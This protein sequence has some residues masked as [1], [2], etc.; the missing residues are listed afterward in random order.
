MG[1][2][3]KIQWTDRG[4]TTTSDGYVLILVGKEH[5]LAD[6]RGYAYEHRLVASRKI[7]RWLEPREEVHHRNEIKHDNHSDN[8]EVCGSR[9]EHRARHRGRDSDLRMPGEDNPTIRC[10]CDCGGELS[11]YDEQGRPRE[12]LSGHND[13]PSPTLD[14]IVE[15]LKGGPKGRS[16]IIDE[17]GLSETAVAVALTKMK[18]RGLIT[19]VSRGIWQAKAGT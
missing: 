4:R 14:A 15:C 13:H 18:L 6:V 11:R 2:A 16:Q 12:Y 5:P 17:S 1:V 8:L 10:A 3:T 9:A 7:G 19:N